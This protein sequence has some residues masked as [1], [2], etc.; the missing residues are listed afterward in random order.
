MYCPW[1]CFC[2][3]PL[4]P[5]V[6]IETAGSLWWCHHG[7]DIYTQRAMQLTTVPPLLLLWTPDKVTTVSSPTGYQIPSF[8]YI[9]IY[10]YHSTQCCDVSQGPSNN[11]YRLLFSSTHMNA[12]QGSTYF[13]YRLPR[14]L[15]V[16]HSPSSPN[17]YTPHF[18]RKYLIICY[19]NDIGFI[20]QWVLLLYFARVH[21]LSSCY[22]S[23]AAAMIVFI[24]I[25]VIIFTTTIASV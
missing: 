11:D 21:W 16:I 23:Q 4:L 1:Q 22:S 15:K 18:L 14:V 19:S 2:L 12:W 5:G 8:T 25:V 24:I 6:S 3:L 13:N 20:S 17:T 7:L 10:V 9:Y